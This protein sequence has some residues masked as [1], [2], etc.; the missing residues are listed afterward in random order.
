[1][2]V[3]RWID[4]GRYDGAQM[5]IAAECPPDGRNRLVV[6]DYVRS[7]LSKHGFE[8]LGDGLWMGDS[9]SFKV[10]DL[11]LWFPGF[12]P[13][14]DIKDIDAADILIGFED[15]DLRDAEAELD[16]LAASPGK[17]AQPS[18]EEQGRRIREQTDAEA[19]NGVIRSF[20]TGGELLARPS[21][22]EDKVRSLTAERLPASAAA[23]LGAINGR[24]GQ[25]RTELA[26]EV[27]RYEELRTKGIHALSNYDIVVAFSGDAVAALRGS[28][29]FKSGHIRT[30]QA[31]LEALVDEANALE[32]P[33]EDDLRDESSSEDSTSQAEAEQEATSRNTP[34]TNIRWTTLRDW[35]KGWRAIERRAPSATRHSQLAAH[36]D[37]L[38]AQSDVIASETS[39]AVLVSAKR[40][41]EGRQPARGTREG[42]PTTEVLQRIG[43]VLNK[44]RSAA[45]DAQHQ[46]R[47][48]SAKALG[49][50]NGMT[51]TYV[52]GSAVWH[53]GDF[54]AKT[55]I[56]LNVYSPLHSGRT[57]YGV[58]RFFDGEYASGTYDNPDSADQAIKAKDR[59]AFEAIAQA[60]VPTEAQQ[61]EENRPDAIDPHAS[62]IEGLRAYVLEAIGNAEAFDGCETEAEKREFVAD[63]LSA[64][65][66]AERLRQFGFAM[67]E[68][69]LEMDGLDPR[70][71]SVDLGG[72]HEV[73][74]SLEQTGAVQVRRLAG[75]EWAEEWDGAYSA[76]ATRQTRDFVQRAMRAPVVHDDEGSE[77][78]TNDPQIEALR[79]R[80]TRDATLRR[81]RGAK[82]P[83]RTR[84]RIEDAGEKIG[85]ARKDFYRSALRASDLAE[86]NERE[87]AEL[88]TKDNVWPSRTIEDYR[89]A[90]VDSRVALFLQYLR[91]EFPQKPGKPEL[92]EPYVELIGKLQKVM[93]TCKTY[94]DVASFAD[95]LGEAG[96]LEISQSSYGKRTA[97]EDRYNDVLYGSMNRPWGFVDNYFYSPEAGYRRAQNAYR[98]R[99]FFVNGEYIRASDLDS[100]G[101]YDLLA[102]LKLRTVERQK[103]TRENRSSDDPDKAALA[104]PHLAK[105]IRDGLPDE[106]DGRDI[107]GDDLLNEFGFRACEFGNWLPDTERQDVLNRAYD[108]FSSLSRVLGVAKRALSLGGTLA[109]AFGSRGAGRW[110]A[111]YECTRKVIN[112]T[113]L[114]GAGSL[115][116]EWGHALDDFVGERVKEALGDS[117]A[118]RD[119][120]HLYFASDMFVKRY[121][122]RRGGKEKFEVYGEDW[123]LPGSVQDLKPIIDLANTIGVRPWSKAE[124]L[125]QVTTDMMSHER[126]LLSALTEVLANIRPDEQPDAVREQARKLVEQV[127]ADA[128]NGER[129]SRS[130]TH[131]LQQSLSDARTPPMRDDQCKRHEYHI[132]RLSTYVADYLDAFELVQDE[133]LRNASEH[134][135]K[136]TYTKYAA[137]AKHFDAKKSDQYWSVMHELTARAFEAY[138]QD[139][140]AENGWRDDYL[141]HGTEESSHEHRLHSAYPMG[142][143]RTSINK[144]MAAYIELVK[145]KFSD[146]LQPQEAHASAPRLRM[147]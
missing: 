60:D 73:H 23:R 56:Q 6:R 100:D 137:D 145:S 9:P 92:I 31:R 105:V 83:E 67:R 63:Y 70:V 44:V 58:R 132:R 3:R 84:E 37:A 111:H 104:R 117:M 5:L 21:P 147:A 61:E 13:S 42:H 86:M 14:R 133:S 99:S 8:K 30:A 66:P 45:R 106:R 40:L 43:T 116:H 25:A 46:A 118:E 139:E 101:F 18:M 109:V 72:G 130:A 112:L 113:R 26:T 135:K 74:A 49:E 134:A 48:D 90:G 16:A 27:A 64:V 95:K 122:E 82:N 4:L 75:E 108:A 80:V 54:N 127:R 144:A 97:M 28:L 123:R 15:L 19:V 36:L 22:S 10:T 69:G 17:G 51:Q 24:L 98:G 47:L 91:R 59:A 107:T 32:Q 121:R 129:F 94:D 7:D 146:E 33:H 53:S 57:R 38:A 68:L 128:L 12:D 120:S 35:V 140:L 96:I 126:K 85:G 50:A 1:V 2:A 124:V 110:N 89:Q 65:E 81:A 141:V 114:R 62:T 55:E 76:E 88:V 34:G 115:A 41:I 29:N 77:G 11:R 78:D 87:K 102:T 39:D 71:W 138:V 125:Q 119:L 79:G 143:D 131:P 103:Q 142:E 20:P 136:R 52:G 93:V